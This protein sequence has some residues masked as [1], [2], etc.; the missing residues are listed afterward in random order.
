MENNGLFFTEQGGDRFVNGFWIKWFS[1]QLCH[2]FEKKKYAPHEFSTKRIEP[3]T[4]I[5]PKWYLAQHVPQLAEF[6][7]SH[8]H[9]DTTLLSEWLT[10]AKVKSS[11][12]VGFAIIFDFLLVFNRAIRLINSA[13]L[14]VIRLQK[15]A[16]L[17]IFKSL[18]VK[19]DGAV[20]FLI[21]E[22]LIETCGLTRLV[23]RTHVFKIQV[24]LKLNVKSNG[25]FALRLYDFQLLFDSNMW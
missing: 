3:D 13:H 11:G 5:Y 18:K 6:Q 16:W 23:Y 19:S 20:G 9:S 10:W 1:R 8:S 24:T 7:Y 15:S 4:S 25:S 12:S 14:R 22:C 2:F 21:Y 17:L